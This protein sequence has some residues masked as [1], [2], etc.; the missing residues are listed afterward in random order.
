MAMTNKLNIDII[1]TSDSELILPL[2]NELKSEVN[3]FAGGISCLVHS[4]D[5]YDVIYFIA[6]HNENII[7]SA[8]VLVYNEACEI[9]K[10]FVSKE[11]RCRSVGSFLVSNIVNYMRSIGKKEMK[12][13][14]INESID[15]WKKTCCN[16]NIDQDLSCMKNIIFTL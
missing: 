3:I 13:E 6:K 11:F 8:T 1:Y 15:F 14:A 4:S 2:Q 5:Y 10:L 9:Y 12:V 16:Y 7:G